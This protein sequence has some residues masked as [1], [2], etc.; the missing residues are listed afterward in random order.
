MNML[1]ISGT[2]VYEADEFYDACDELGILVWHDVMFANMDLPDSPEFVAEVE[3]EVVQLLARVGHRPSLAVLCGGSEVEQQAA[4]LGL[5]RERWTM[6]LFDEV[7]PAIAEHVVPGLPYVTSSPTGGTLPFHNDAGIAHYYGVGAYRRPVTDVRR[8][9]VRFATECLAFANVPDAFTAADDQSRRGVPRDNG[10]EWDFADVR[11]HY[12]HTLFDIDPEALRATDPTRALDLGR[13]AVG[14]LVA[15]TLAE[16]RR[17]GS[18]CSGALIWTLRDLYPGAG[19]GLVDA[20]GQ[21]KAVWWYARRAMEPVGVFALDEG[22]NGLHL[23]V[24]N[25][26]AAAIEGTLRVELFARG[27]LLS[28]SAQQ[29]IKVAGRRGQVVSADAM[30]DGFRDLTW[31]YRFGEANYDVVAATLL[32]NDDEPVAR[33]FHLPLG[34]ARELEPDIGLSAD[35]TPGNDGGWELTIRS[36]RFAQSVAVRVDGFRPDDNWF[37]VAP[38]TPHKLQLEPLDASSVTPAGEVRA[39]NTVSGCRIRVGE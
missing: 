35:A 1:R 39:I 15:A 12:V 33:A 8:A 29:P 3:A 24:V 13:V 28:E 30:F 19:W 25:D 4:M 26:G 22:L 7:I 20:F 9:D 14:E 10:A 6:P 37:H 31:A 32:T 34:L 5:P 27:E 11:D 23:H 18:R 16:W 2:T 17:V 21:P 36:K 38:G